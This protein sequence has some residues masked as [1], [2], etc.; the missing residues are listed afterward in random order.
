MGFLKRRKQEKQAREGVLGELDRYTEL[1]NRASATAGVDVAS[2]IGAGEQ[3]MA[4]GSLQQMAAYSARVA[5]V[6]QA[7]VEMPAVIQAVELGAPSPLQGGIP[8]Q[9]HLTVEPHGGAP[10]DVTTDQVMHESMASALA[11]GQRVTVKVDPSDPQAL[12]VWS[13]EAAPVAGVDERL[14][15]LEELRDA[16]VLTD[17]EFEAQKDKPQGG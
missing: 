5:R 10:Y 16:G 17:A 3:A 9:L 1:A 2:I 11:P 7:G 6:A 12:I 15:K 13:T 8:A 4:D 14:A